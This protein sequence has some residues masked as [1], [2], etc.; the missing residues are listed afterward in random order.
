MSTRNGFD[1]IRVLLNNIP[2][3]QASGVWVGNANVITT[4]DPG[5]Y[6][7]NYNVSYT[8]NGAGPITN[9]QTIITTGNTFTSGLGQVVVSTPLTGQMG[10]LGTDSMRQTLSNTFVI[11]AENTPIYVYLSC[12][13][14]GQWGTT[15]VNE[16]EL[17]TITF[18]K[19]SS[20]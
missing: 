6:F 18:T 19:I 16:T 10:L 17:N 3:T 5:I 12:T 1:S 15:N 4:L 7:V 9:S 11:N 14:T 2:N 20:L 13:L 8:V